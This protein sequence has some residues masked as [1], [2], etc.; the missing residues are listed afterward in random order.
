MIN[1]NIL[2]FIDACVAG[3][4][5][6]GLI[7]VL[8]NLPA[9]FT[10]QY[11]E[12]THAQVRFATLDGL[13]GI[14]ALWVVLTHVWSYYFTYFRGKVWDWPSN[15]YFN[16]CGNVA[17]PMFLMITGFLFWGKAIRARGLLNPIKLYINRA[18]RVLPL[19]YFLCFVV[20]LICFSLSPSLVQESGA[21]ILSELGSLII[22]GKN[23]IGP[24]A[25]IERFFLITPTWTLY[26]EVVF[27]LVLPVIGMAAVTTY[28]SWVFLGL[29]LYGFQLPW[30]E[31]HPYFYASFWVGAITAELIERAKINLL[32]FRARSFGLLIVLLVF[33][34]PLITRGELNL[35][36]FCLVAL[37]FITIVAGNSCLGLLLNPGTQILG[38]I[39]Y[40]IYLLHMPFLFL[41][42]TWI[43]RFLVIGKLSTLQYVP[44][45]VIYLLFIV[46]L[47]LLSYRFIEKRS[48][49][50]KINFKLA[51]SRAN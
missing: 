17:V 4:A 1:I 50:C 20:L 39:S 3:C 48:V 13:R 32:Y 19:Y 40:S 30:A 9:S 10:S 15:P 38:T 26:F 29:A 49:D 2:Y 6:L 21:T 22:P 24:I 11:K 7:F 28:S 36:S 37:A 8:G 27:Y 47:S 34:V 5:I 51:K 25:G 18:K 23:F 45:E 12:K 16:Q 44:I 42:L 35:F 33:I 43:N 14:L 46:Y 31:E 41:W